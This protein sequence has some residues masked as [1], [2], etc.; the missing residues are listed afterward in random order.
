MARRKRNRQPDVL[1][2]L[3]RD[4]QREKQR[5]KEMIDEVP[6]IDKVPFIRCPP[7]KAQDYFREY[8]HDEET[9]KKAWTPQFI[10][11]P[12]P[13]GVWERRFEPPQFINAPTPNHQVWERCL[14]QTRLSFAYAIVSVQGMVAQHDEQDEK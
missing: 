7:L 6:F 4:H 14:E 2:R 3:L 8:D 5:E 10:S 13:D 11:A 1:T 9:S 12:T